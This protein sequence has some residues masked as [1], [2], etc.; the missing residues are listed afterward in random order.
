MA[1]EITTRV[2]QSERVYKIRATLKSL[3]T[4]VDPEAF[5]LEDANR[6]EIISRAGLPANTIFISAVLLQE[7]YIGDI[8]FYV[9]LLTLE[10]LPPT[11]TAHTHGPDTLFMPLRESYRDGPYIDLDPTL[12]PVDIWATKGTV[13]YLKIRDGSDIFLEIDQDGHVHLGGHVEFTSDTQYDI[14]SLDDGVTLRRPRDVFV[15]RDTYTARDGYFG[16]SAKSPLYKFFEQ[17]TNPDTDPATRHIYWDSVD[18]LP[19]GWDGTTDFPL[20]GGGPLVDH[21]GVIFISDL[22]PDAGNIVCTFAENGTRVVSAAASP[23]VTTI[24]VHVFA[25]TGHEQVRP[26]VDINGVPAVWSTAPQKDPIAYEGTADL[27]G[28]TLPLTI[29]AT[30]QDG[31]S[32]EIV[33]GEDPAPVISLLEFANGYPGTQTELKAG[34]TFDIHI[35]TDLNFVEVEVENSG[36]CAAMSFA[37]GATNDYTFAATIAD[38]GLATQALPARLRVRRSTGTWSDWVYTNQ[39][40]GTVDGKDLVNLNNT[41]PYI[42]PM[43]QLSITYPALQ[44]AIKD[45]ETVTVH[46]ACSDF[47]TISYTSP[48]G[49]LTIPSPAVYAADKVGVARNS[50]GY[51]ITTLNYRITAT[52]AANDATSTES[53][54]VYIAHD[55]AQIQM[56]EPA[57]R[58]RTGG[59]DGTSPQNHTITLTSNQR[60][61]SAPTV[62]NPPAGGG[63]WQGA[64]FVG[65]PIIWTR[66]LQCHDNDTVGIYSYGLLSATNLAGRV[67]TSYTG[68]SNYVIG[69][70][71][72]RTL[73][74][75]AFTNEVVFN[76]AVADYS[77]CTLLWVIKDLPNRRAFNTVATPDPNS[78]CFAG[79]LGLSPTTARILDT[80]ATSSSSDDT[81][82]TVEETV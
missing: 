65:G 6:N 23:D 17:A 36:A 56:S 30:H 34:D 52:R 68:S 78:W 3:T 9:V 47:D 35:Q 4:I 29:T 71:V 40:G 60:L 44:Q 25:Y 51:N 62:A 41:Y 24:T 42:Q 55:F 32:Y 31:N 45:V 57:S 27:S 8:H 2:V 43:N 80:A 21:D 19:H 39:A 5:V 54:V 38:R 77:K 37:V 15:G 69:G 14:G 26:D 11:A 79:T 28:F 7:G 74:L 64:G 18:N 67:T 53:T 16:T 82:V 81:D 75:T 73:T 22:T 50:G 46:S 48:T 72:S 49:E 10:N 58:L 76:A 66:S 61:I 70:F 12:G 59:N 20:V 1:V 63:A 13:D 33:V